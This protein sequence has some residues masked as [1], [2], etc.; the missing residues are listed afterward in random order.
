MDLLLRLIFPLGFF[1]FGV[2]LIID[3]MGVELHFTRWERAVL[4][5]VFA[6]ICAAFTFADFSRDS[7]VFWDALTRLLFALVIIIVG[8]K[9]LRVLIKLHTSY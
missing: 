2:R 5:F 7:G 4:S 9:T 6:T 3:L 1:I 8:S